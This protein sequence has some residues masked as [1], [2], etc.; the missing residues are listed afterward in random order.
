MEVG[1]EQGKSESEDTK[2]FPSGQFLK[3]AYN[4]NAV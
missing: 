3:A 2:I 1:R 4:L